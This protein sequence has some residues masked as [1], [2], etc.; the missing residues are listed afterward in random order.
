MRQTP[1]WSNDG[2]AIVSRSSSHPSFSPVNQSA[3]NR[4]AS[5]VGAP[6]ATAGRS[7]LTRNTGRCVRTVPGNGGPG[8][9]EYWQQ[10]RESNPAIVERNRQLQRV[11]DQKRKLRDL[12]NNNSAFDLKHSATQIWLVGTDL[13][14]LANNNP[15][16]AQVWVL[17]VLPPRRGP[18]RE[19]CQQQRSGVDSVSAG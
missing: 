18:Y 5:D 6:I 10:R 19:S 15:A 13:E 8:N 17:E 3:A 2:V 12:A 11:R 9:P 1:V 16:T 14:D 4:I 7:P